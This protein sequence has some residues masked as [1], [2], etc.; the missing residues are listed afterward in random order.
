[1]V[2]A[3]IAAGTLVV[4]GCATSTSTETPTPTSVPTTAAV[5]VPAGPVEGTAPGTALD[6]GDTAVLPADAFDATG[7]RAM[8]TV[9]GITPAEGVPDDISDG[10]TPYFL[11]VTVTSLTRRPTAAPSVIGLSGRPDGRA[12]TLTR[13]PVPGLTDCP[14]T[15]PPERMRCGESYSTCLISVADAG[16]R[17]EQVIYWAD[18]TSDV[19]LDYQRAPVS[20]ALPGASAAPSTSA[21]G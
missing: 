12:P 18:T 3:M 8:F 9:T 7:P 2:V 17:V 21:A 19:S 10:G 5:T 20:W 14:D 16:E 1:V 6:F 13:A 4:P 11:Y 15:A